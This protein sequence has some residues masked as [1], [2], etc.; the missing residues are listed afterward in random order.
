MKKNNKTNKITLQK[1]FV[2]FEQPDFLPDGFEFIDFNTF[3]KKS[4]KNSCDDILIGDLLEYFDYSD[5]SETLSNIVNRL[6]NKKK[7]FIQGVDAKFVSYHFATDQMNLDVFNAFVFGVGKKYLYNISKI[8]NLLKT[9]DNI[10]I[11][12]IKFINSFNYYIECE[13]K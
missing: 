5:C 9:N 10:D 12:S 13:K 4:K 2:H 11:L 6:Q 1:Y 7:L 3:L 8:K